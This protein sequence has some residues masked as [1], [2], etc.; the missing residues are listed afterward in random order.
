MAKQRYQNTGL[1]GGVGL[2]FNRRIQNQS[3]QRCADLGVGGV[4]SA[5]QHQSGAL[6]YK[7]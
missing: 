5:H 7:S 3:K 4:S 2:N 1:G 6:P